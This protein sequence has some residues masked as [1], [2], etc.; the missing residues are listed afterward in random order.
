MPPLPACSPIPCGARKPTRRIRTAG[1][2]W[3][4]AVGQT[5]ITFSPTQTVANP[6]LL[7]LTSNTATNQSL[8]STAYLFDT[9]HFTVLTVI[10][11][12]PLL[13]PT[14]VGIHRK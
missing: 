11:P 8:F 1:V 10:L 13:P 6:C 4:D 7:A 5:N 12:T 9:N 2:G 14:F 3:G